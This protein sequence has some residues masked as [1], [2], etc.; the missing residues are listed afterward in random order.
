LSVGVYVIKERGVFAGARFLQP[1][2][3]LVV[4]RDEIDSWS[5]I[6]IRVS[7]EGGVRL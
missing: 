3:P 6:T 2:N 4:W 7:C 5:E 1:E